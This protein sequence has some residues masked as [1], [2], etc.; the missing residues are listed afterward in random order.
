MCSPHPQA[1][2]IMKKCI[3]SSPPHH[4]Q[5]PNSP[6]PFLW[7][8]QLAAGI[9][10]QTQII[11]MYVYMYVGISKPNLSSLGSK[12][13]AFQLHCF[14]SPLHRFFRPLLSLSVHLLPLLH[15]H[16]LTK[17][18]PLPS[19]ISPFQLTFILSTISSTYSPPCLFLT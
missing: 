1:K 8:M 3:H 10:I 6:I 19:H 2:P 17:R 18:N 7:G 5:F 15:L 11:C 9:H 12:A 4:P 14:T 13:Q 16:P